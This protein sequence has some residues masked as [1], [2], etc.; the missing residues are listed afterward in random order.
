MTTTQASTGQS[1]RTALDVLNRALRLEYSLIIH[2]PRIANSIP[3]EETRKLVQQLGEAST[4]HADVV[5][6]AIK[7]LGGEPDW[8]F[9]P[10]PEQRD[11][12]SIMRTQLEKE[13]MALEL[14]ER[15]AGLVHSRS[16]RDQLRTL[17]REEEAHIHTVEQI[18]ERLTTI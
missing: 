10:F 11:P 1:S 18:L 9:A 13:K 12:E 16:M 6:D 14:H 3:D 4:H 8:S 17:A 15:A 2:Y 5:A 7:E